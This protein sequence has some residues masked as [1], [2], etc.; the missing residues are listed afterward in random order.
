M[1]WELEC[2]VSI[3]VFRFDH[4]Q[5]PTPFRSVVNTR[6][7]GDQFSKALDNGKFSKTRKNVLSVISFSR[8]RLFHWLPRILHLGLC[9]VASHFRIQQF[10][11]CGTFF[12]FWTLPLK[13][14][15]TKFLIQNGLS[16]RYG[17]DERTFTT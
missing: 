8:L 12:T 16:V 2:A 10:S 9:D 15:E 14:V 3:L 13:I 1:I 17:M 6:Y 11:R 4:H 5:S 7:N